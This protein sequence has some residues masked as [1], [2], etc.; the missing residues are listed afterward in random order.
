M[1]KGSKSKFN[2]SPGLTLLGIVPK[3]LLRKVIL[4]QGFSLIQPC[5]S[6]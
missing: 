3:I 1:Y 5:H 4:F 2:L 6:Y